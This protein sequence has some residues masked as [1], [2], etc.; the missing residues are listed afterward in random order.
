MYKDFRAA[1]LQILGSADE[2]NLNGVSGV[3]NDGIPGEIVGVEPAPPRAHERNLRSQE[4]ENNVLPPR[5]KVR[6][7]GKEVE[8]A[9]MT[10]DPLPASVP[11]VMPVN[12]HV[13]RT[14]SPK[15]RESNL[16]ME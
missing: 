13:E 10:E 8:E 2:Q 1:I 7:R 15:V 3:G 9:E 6:S 11:V 4:R 5:G 14:A 16:S 12:G